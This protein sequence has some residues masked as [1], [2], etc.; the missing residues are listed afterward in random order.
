MRAEGVQCF[1]RG[2]SQGD[3]GGILEDGLP[4]PWLGLTLNGDGFGHAVAL[5]YTINDGYISR[6]TILFR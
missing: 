5:F 1:Q 3:E 6:C 4:H 2:I